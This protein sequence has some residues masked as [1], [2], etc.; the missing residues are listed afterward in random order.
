MASHYKNLLEE[1]VKNPNARLLD[2][3]L[4]KNDRQHGL[5]ENSELQFEDKPELFNF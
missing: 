5:K 4:E 1:I 3:A 2:I